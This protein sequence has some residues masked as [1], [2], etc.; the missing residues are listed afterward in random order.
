MR[1]KAIFWLGQRN[2]PRIRQILMDI[3]TKP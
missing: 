3:I 1:K 2:D